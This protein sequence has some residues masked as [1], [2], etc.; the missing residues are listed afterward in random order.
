[1]IASLWQQASTALS[2]AWVLRSPR[3]QQ[4]L[5][6]GGAAL[7]LAVVWSLA[8]APAL[9]TWQEAPVRQA[10]LDA[11]TQSMHHLRAQAQ[12]LQQPSP[13][14]RT[15]AIGWLEKSLSDLGP[16]ARITFESDRATVSLSAAPSVALA[17]W[18]SQARENAQA[19]PLQAQLQRIAE[20]T[21]PAA[22]PGSWRGNI[23]LRL[24]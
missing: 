14:K 11:Q 20:P 19:L 12:G 1:M 22:A 3:E 23:V 4:L 24:P 2:K 6:L 8:L 18:L 10:S 13:I 9:R 15:E 16:D 17:R 21:A 5:T 7:L